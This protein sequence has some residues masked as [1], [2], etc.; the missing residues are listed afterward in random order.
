MKSFLL[1]LGAVGMMALIGITLNTPPAFAID[2]VATSATLVNAAL[3]PADCSV[4]GTTP[5]LSGANVAASGNVKCS[6]SRSLLVVETCIQHR[7]PIVGE[8]VSW[9]DLAC[10]AGTA[11]DA[12][13]A[14]ASVTGKC[15]PGNWSYRTVVTAE[16]HRRDHVEKNGTGLAVIGPVSLYCPI[17]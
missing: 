8:N 13:S 6:D 9:Q 7:Q 2:P 1:H 17:Y 15:V 14:N 3:L 12:T 11:Q 4:G 16:V 5:S 10:N